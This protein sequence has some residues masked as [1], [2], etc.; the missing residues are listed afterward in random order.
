[1]NDEVIVGGVRF[2]REFAVKALQELQLA[3]AEPQKPALKTGMIV[4][5]PKG[6][7]IYTTDFTI[8][9]GGEAYPVDQLRAH[10]TPVTG[11]CEN[12]FFT[13][14]ESPAK[15]TMGHLKAP[16]GWTL[17]GEYISGVDHGDE[18]DWGW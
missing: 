9:L 15:D 18:N 11:Y 6:V 3:L 12:G 5:T 13:F 2:D 4:Q 7:G 17:E 8:E 14:A 10:I 16:S 1:M